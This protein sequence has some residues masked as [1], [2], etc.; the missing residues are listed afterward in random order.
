[1]A[2]PAPTTGRSPAIATTRSEQIA[3][4]LDSAVSADQLEQGDGELDMQSQI[5]FP[6]RTVMFGQLSTYGDDDKAT[7]TVP[8]IGY[9]QNDKLFALRVDDSRLRNASW[10]YICTGPQPT[11]L[12]GVL[13]A[14]L[15]EKQPDLVLVHS[16]DSGRTF[17]LTSVFKPL[18][19]CEFDSFCMDRTGHGRVSVYV[20]RTK[21]R[22]RHAG[23]YNYRTTD[24][25]QTWSAPEFEPDAMTPAD[26]V[27][28]DQSKSTDK[29][30]RV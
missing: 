2:A 22:L 8:V 6:R 9:R 30:S 26:D 1:M 11:E 3:L 5:P 27:P 7:A 4:S 16:T 12:W 24:G 19:S 23:Y 14:S 25:G 17:A 20:D 21:T 28:G 29:P 15:D 18:P 10:S 13:D